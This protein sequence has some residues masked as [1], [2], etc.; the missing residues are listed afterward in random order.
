M[1]WLRLK[2][3]PEA[4]DEAEFEPYLQRQRG[5]GLE[6]ATMAEL[7]DTPDHRRALYEL[8]KTCSAD[9]PD[10]SAAPPWTAIAGPAGSGSGLSA[11]ASPHATAVR[12]ASAM[13]TAT[14][15]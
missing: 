4:F 11:A 2:P 12:T 5:A 8:N 10:R 14:I 1:E 15:G 7:G 9:I 3:D 13:S 6:F